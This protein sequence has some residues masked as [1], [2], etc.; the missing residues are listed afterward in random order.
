MSK[1]KDK[2]Y[3]VEDVVRDRQLFR[4]VE[5]LIIKT[6]YEDG[7][8]VLITLPKDAGAQSQ[9]YASMLQAK[10]ADLGFTVRLI[11]PIADKVTRFG[12]F[13]SMAE[14]GYVKYV[15]G[16]WNKT[17]FTELEQF[18]GSRNIKEIRSMLQVTHLTN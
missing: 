15:E 12:P 10:I 11:K 17:Y 6:A 13:S 14:A 8:D 18:D 9:S 4:G 5:E 2:D 3:I 1:T 16:D 7:K